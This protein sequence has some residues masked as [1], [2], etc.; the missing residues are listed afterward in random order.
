MRKVYLLMAVAAIMVVGCKNIGSKK[1]AAEA[2]AA[3]A[4]AEEAAAA[5]AE[6]INQ[7]IEEVEAAEGMTALEAVEALSRAQLVEGASLSDELAGDPNFAV[8]FA[9]VEQKPTFNGGD[10][11]D[12]SKWV[13]ENIVYP[14]DAKNRQVSGRVILQFT[15]G[16]E[17][18][19]KDV[20]V[21]K[22]VDPVLDAEAVRVISAS[23][24]WE[25]G[26]QNGIPVNVKYTFP[27]VF[28]LN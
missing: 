7:A 25:P 15:I 22:G 20:E 23:P 3:E 27:V 12:F 2:A 19:V 10:A 4:A 24:K 26:D 14:D 17:G 9:A 1:A 5:Q 8:P 21:I 11:N 13:A 16:K 28:K 18:E 6:R